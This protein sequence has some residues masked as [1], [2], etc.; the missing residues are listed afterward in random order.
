M[1]Y[2][3]SMNDDVGEAYVIFNPDEVL[4]PPEFIGRTDWPATYAHQATG[5]IVEYR[6]SIIDR[7]GQTFGR[8]DDYRRRF[9]SLRTGR[10][11]R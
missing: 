8:R 6:E 1:Q 10:Q 11:I 2:T 9:Y 4:L 3:I 7:D 5:E